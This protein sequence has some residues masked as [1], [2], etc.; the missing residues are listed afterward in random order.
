MKLG[1]DKAVV[2]AD[3]NGPATAKCLFPPVRV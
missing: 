3:G 2:E 1:V